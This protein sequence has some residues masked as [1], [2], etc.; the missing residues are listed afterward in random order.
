MHEEDLGQCTFPCIEV[1]TRK[2]CPHKK[3]PP[4]PPPPP[5]AFIAVTGL[6]A[7]MAVVS[8]SPGGLSPTASRISP[9]P[10]PPQPAVRS[11]STGTGRVP[12]V[13]NTSP[14]VRSTTSSNPLSEYL[15]ICMREGW[16]TLLPISSVEDAIRYLLP[17]LDTSVPRDPADETFLEFIYYFH[18]AVKG[19]DFAYFLERT[20]P[21]RNEILREATVE[22]GGIVTE[23]PDYAFLMID[24]LIRFGGSEF[25]SSN[26]DMKRVVFPS[27]LQD[28]KQIILDNQD[29]VVF[30]WGV[31]VPVKRL[32]D[33][34]SMP[35]DV[36]EN[37]A[38]L[39]FNQRAFQ[40]Y[41]E[42]QKATMNTN[43]GWVPVILATGESGYISSRYAYPSNGPRLVVKGNNN[44]WKYEF[45][46]PERPQRN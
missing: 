44:N 26:P 39:K 31:N 15:D 28:Y 25:P 4:P 10:Q 35:I 45:T 42:R 12:S 6:A 29:E 32:P 3:K 40:A 13:P 8:S 37:Y 21:E 33:P 17:Q 11:L 30:V 34:N 27:F 46:V 38:F 24:R 5:Y 19:C 14:A 41:T 7:T 20:H 43:N 16:K 2:G 36:I 1:C 18:E 23:Q 9:G 22:T